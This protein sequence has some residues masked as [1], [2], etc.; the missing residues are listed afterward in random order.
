MSEKEI[1][2][3]GQCMDSTSA[4]ILPLFIIMVIMW[5]ILG[6][7]EGLRLLYRILFKH[8]K[9]DHGELNQP[10]ENIV[11]VGEEK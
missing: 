7:F 4:L 6:V 3:M 11:E 1:G 9:Y 2:P 8:E 5:I 10:P